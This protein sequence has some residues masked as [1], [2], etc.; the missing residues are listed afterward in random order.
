MDPLQRHHDPRE[1]LA[2]FDN[3]SFDND[4]ARNL[5]IWRLSVD[6]RLQQYTHCTSTIGPFQIQVQMSA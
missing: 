5:G 6:E 3:Y 4:N 2:Y 1:M